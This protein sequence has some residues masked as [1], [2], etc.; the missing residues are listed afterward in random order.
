MGKAILSSAEGLAGLGVVGA[1]A[2]A[3]VVIWLSN[4]Y[5]YYVNQ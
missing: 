2:G 1:G 3:A 4:E 5:E